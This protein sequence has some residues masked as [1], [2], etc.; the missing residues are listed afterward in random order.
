M[1]FVCFRIEIF[2]K[3]YVFDIL[4]MWY[5]NV[6]MLNYAMKINI[7]ICHDFVNYWWA[8]IFSERV[9]LATLIFNHDIPLP[10][11]SINSRLLYSNHISCRY[12]VKN[13]KKVITEHREICYQDC[14]KIYY[15]R[16]LSVVTRS[17][18]SLIYRRMCAGTIPRTIHV[19]II[20]YIY[21]RISPI[22]NNGIGRIRISG[23]YIW[24]R[25]V[26]RIGWRWKR[27]KDS[28][29]SRQSSSFRSSWFPQL[30]QLSES[31]SPFLSPSSRNPN[32]PRWDTDWVHGWRKKKGIW[33]KRTGK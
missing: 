20:I 5:G 30:R 21:I 23:N 2:K 25:R 4:L 17:Y 1:E 27:I 24:N 7:F 8:I 26:E 33:E 6:P 3:C 9:F 28:F 29:S 16:S 13:N 31:R 15:I 10:D 14:G 32:N 22:T 12:I 18:Q 19:Y 11:I